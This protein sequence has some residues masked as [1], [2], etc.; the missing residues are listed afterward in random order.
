MTIL[1]L[2][3]TR[4]VGRH[5]VDALLRRGHTVAVLTR[6]VSPDD[7]PASVE[8][9]RGNRND[10]S[11]VLAALAGRSWDACIDVS[12]YLP[13]QVRPT[14]EGLADRI[15]RYLFISTVSVY[16]DLSG[17]PV[18]EAGRLL[19][20]A[21][22]TVTD[23]T[24]ET[25]GPLKVTCERIV[26]DTYG[27][28]SSFLRPQIVAGPHDPTGRHTYWVQRAMQGGGML[29]PGDG[30]DHVQVVDARDVARFAASVIDRD[31]SGTFNMAGPRLTWAEF[32]GAL[33]AATPVWVPVGVIR[34]Q[35]LTMAQL[36]LFV[37]DGAPFSGVM[38]VSA[39]RA[40]EAGFTT[41]DPQTTINDT[42]AWLTDHPIE[43]V[44]SPEREREIIAA[45][46]ARG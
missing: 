46:R 44:L 20:E 35:E 5:I 29:A 31:L 42:R 33:G 28:R 18:T 45:A 12:G 39:A 26:R 14:A 43:L 25:Y 17:G 23:V 30:S 6:G 3:G 7:L 16:Q 27:Q 13:R 21:A 41:T 2:G 34:A 10:P 38:N 8:R 11:G 36:P 40:E 37:A 1:V 32:V 24:S 9:L 4:F 19:P 22:E 15:A